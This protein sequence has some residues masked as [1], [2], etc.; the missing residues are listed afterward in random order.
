MNQ[1]DCSSMFDHMQSADTEILT[2]ER[3]FLGGILLD[4]GQT[5]PPLLPQ[6]FFSDRHAQLWE[7]IL[8]LADG[9]TAPELAQAL[10]DHDQ[11]DAVGGGAYLAQCIEEG[12]MVI[13]ALVPR[14]AAL[15]RDACR[16]RLLKALGRD[17]AAQG[18]NE[19]EVGRRLAEVP[20]RLQ[21]V[22]PWSASRTW[23]A[24]RQTLVTAPPVSTGLQILDA[25]ISGFLPGE[26]VVVGGRTSHGKTAFGVHLALHAA[27]AGVPTLLL[28]L[29]ETPA[30]VTARAV[31]A[32]TDIPYR[33]LA[34][35]PLLSDLERQQIDDALGELDDLPWSVLTVETLRAL[36]EDTVCGAVATSQARMVIIDHLQKITTAGESR[37]YGV[38]RVMNR[39]HAAALRDNRVVVVCAQLNRESE[40][41]QRAP[42]LSDLRDSG[43]VE[44]LAR[45]VLLLYWPCRHDAARDRHQYQILV[46]KQATGGVGTVQVRFRAETGAFWEATP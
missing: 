46:A 19:T 32:R 5:L 14:Y 22:E 35:N 11:L 3:A 18:F 28:S 25:E 43:A 26:L 20:G 15:I 39:L 13:P 34:S 23:A 12:W 45:K 36:D 29:E 33:R 9:V 2:V 42:R 31:A 17:L 41:E 27:R 10:A 21:A 40:Y 16:R 8:D 37:Q 30:L 1:K 4:R 7:R 38:E 44:I 24:Y 6:E